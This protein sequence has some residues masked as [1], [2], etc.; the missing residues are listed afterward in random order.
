MEVIHSSPRR[1][2]MILSEKVNIEKIFI[3]MFF[4]ACTFLPSC[5]ER[6]E[7]EKIYRVGIMS[8]SEAFVHMSDGFKEEMAKLGYV[9]GKNISYDLR[10]AGP[11][12]EQQVATEIIGQNVDLIFAFP[13]EPAVAA[14][15]AAKST[16]IPVVFA[17]AGIEGT[18]LV[19]SL[20]RPG[21]NITGVR[22]PSPESTCK[23]LEL[24]R[25]LVPYAKR[26]WII[27]DPNY[28]LTGPSL[29]ML[30]PAARSLGITLLETPAH[31][32]EDVRKALQEK[33]DSGDI[34]IDAILIM[35]EVLTQTPDGFG[36]ILEFANKH[37]V[38]IAGAMDY[39][40]DRGALFNQAPDV[41]EM[42]RQAATLVDK[43]L[44]GTPAGSIPVMTPVLYFRLNYKAIQRLGL[45]VNEGLLGMADEIIR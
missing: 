24:L 39:T 9:E 22:F 31:N 6:T 13:T 28:P 21:G 41:I 34:D 32:L 15:A 25:E 27:H 23:R 5:T 14:K 4:L 12:K 33:T 43:I 40:T 20:Q 7:K 19:E 38:P 45:N 36:A 37:N 1:N 18:G 16:D 30:R 3:I 35:P 26:V 8:G 44:K 29:E 42:G 17:L 10:D 2:E 11:D